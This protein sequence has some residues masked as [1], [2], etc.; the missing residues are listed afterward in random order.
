MKG[1]GEEKFKKIKI[2]N[3]KHDVIVKNKTLG[4]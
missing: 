1:I 2:S 3:R 4:S